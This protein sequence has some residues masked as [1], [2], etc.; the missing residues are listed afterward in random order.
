MSNEIIEIFLF[1]DPL[2]KR[3]NN[4][5]KMMEKL[6]EERTEKIKFRIVPIA[7][8]RR[9]YGYTCK[10]CGSDR[11][12]F[13]DMNNH[14]STNTYRACLAFHASGM[15]GKNK[16]H[17]F[18]SVLQETVTENDVSF[19]EDVLYQVAEQINLDM[20]MFKDDYRSELAKKI[21]RQNLNL[22][23]NMDISGTPSCVI[24]KNDTEDE[25]VRL[26]EKIEEDVL[27]AICGLEHN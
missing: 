12:T 25:A 16:A 23:S 9:I 5:R 27:Y 22:A 13:V 14:F 17:Q 11:K 26:D 8:F 4:V 10:K 21:Y 3:C 2:G 24:Y 7:N 1:V 19:S 15:Q 6:R 18:L 20:E